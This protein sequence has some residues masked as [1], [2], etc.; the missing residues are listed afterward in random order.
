MAIECLKSDKEISHQ[1]FKGALHILT[2]E[3]RCFIYSWCD[4]L[5]VLPAVIRAQHSD[6]ESIVEL[7]K[8]WYY[9]TSRTFS[10]FVPGSIPVFKPK[11]RRLL[12]LR[13][14][15]CLPLPTP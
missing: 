12:L 8:D 7:L 10:D 1:T 2:G 13:E 9:R 15:I 3:P 6:K 11:V 14:P 5:K 4:A